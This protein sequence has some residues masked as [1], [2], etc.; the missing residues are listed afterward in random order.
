MAVEVQKE[1]GEEARLSLLRRVGSIALAL[2]IGT[3]GGTAAY[4][5][6]LPLPWMI[7]S[8]SATTVAAILGAPIAMAKGLR[9]VMVTVLGVMLGSGFTPEIMAHFATWLPTLGLL[10][11][12]V[13]AAG[14][15]GT[16]YVQRL[17]GYDR[18][19]AYFSAM[20]GGLSEMILVGTAMGG[21]A[22]R[23]SLVHGS[24]LLLVVMII[25][26][27]YN[28]VHGLE[29]GERPPIGPSL[30]DL[31]LDDLLLLAMAAVVGY[32]LARALRI[33]AAAVVGPMLVS[34]AIHLVGWTSA[35][36]PLE[37]VAAAQVAVG[38]AVG[39]RFSNTATRLVF[40]T[41]L[42]AAGGAAIL[43]ALAGLFSVGV[44]LVLPLSLDAV[45]LAFSPGGLAEMSLIAI[46]I[47]AD[48]AFV[49]THHIV[50]IILIVV[51][52]PPAF[53]L[54]GRWERARS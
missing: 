51:L 54:L 9:A 29:A 11:F 5:L 2:G 21:D 16:L 48:T 31:P 20:P 12:Y 24:R 14:S 25:P 34:A 27:L 6:Q 44:S 45:L 7:G 37:L 22:R 3:A 13:A 36:P 1:I 50:R 47:G 41:L 40:Q 30:L 18:P 8:M 38:A 52:A 32:A 10:F 35:K 28:Y 42:H 23:I 4:L 33:P 19:T 15:L 17:C 26:F 43:M 49:A 53:R 46:A 39:A